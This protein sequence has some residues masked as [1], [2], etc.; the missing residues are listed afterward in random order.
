MRGDSDPVTNG[1]ALRSA[2]NAISGATAQKPYVLS[3]AAGTFDLG[4]G[5]GLTLPQHV[6]LVGAGRG[7]TTIRGNYPSQS[8]GLVNL[9]VGTTVAALS[10]TNA[11]TG[12]TSW[13]IGIMANGAG[14]P[15]LVDVAATASGAAESFGLLV[16]NGAQVTVDRGTY[17]GSN[18]ALGTGIY[19]ILNASVLA[20][21]VEAVSSA[22]SGFSLRVENSAT[23]VF[24]QGFLNGHAKRM[25]PDS[26]VK[27]GHSRLDGGSAGG[28]QCFGVH[29]TA[30][31]A[32]TC[33]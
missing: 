1:T 23:V 27:I 22:P 19:A 20:R 9:N 13:S 25:T 4:T 17:V 8:G 26:T 5:S 6:S 18:G 10:V 7:I 2:L 29:D 30:W 33:A 3:L 28:V 15:R 16:F 14:A 11:V 31:N 12:T 21:G 24:E 32:V